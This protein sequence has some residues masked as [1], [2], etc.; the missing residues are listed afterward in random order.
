MIDVTDPVR[1]GE[2]ESGLQAGTNEK[3]C[4][5]LDRSLFYFRYRQLFLSAELRTADCPIRYRLALRRF[6][7]AQN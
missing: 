4:V 1:V 6:E 7:P 2:T 3:G 5:I